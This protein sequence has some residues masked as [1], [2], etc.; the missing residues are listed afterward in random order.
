MMI[1]SW[2]AHE[3]LYHRGD[4]CKCQTFYGCRSRGAVGS[5][6]IDRSLVYLTRTEI[7]PAFDYYT[8]CRWNRLWRVNLCF[9]PQQWTIPIS[10]HNE[11]YMR[12]T[13]TYFTKDLHLQPTMHFNS[14]EYLF[15]IVFFFCLFTKQK[16]IHYLRTFNFVLLFSVFNKL[17]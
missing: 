14:I 3:D 11:I 9:D 16:L 10:V 8:A 12:R 15:C 5:P 7:R 6:S 1:F 2:F 17:S 4:V 13:S